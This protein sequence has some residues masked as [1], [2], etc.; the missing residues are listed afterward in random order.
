V[1]K[2]GDLV[3]L[4]KFFGGLQDTFI[5]TAQEDETARVVS[6]NE[7]SEKFNAIHLWHIQI[8]KDEI[9]WRSSLVYRLQSV[10]STFARDN[11]TKAQINE[12]SFLYL[13]DE[14]FIVYHQYFNFRL[15]DHDFPVITAS[16]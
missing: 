12:R 9:R 6:L 10:N 7:M 4:Y 13:Q 14:R 3:S 2:Q 11:R 1:S 15:V 5:F 16:Y 8:Q